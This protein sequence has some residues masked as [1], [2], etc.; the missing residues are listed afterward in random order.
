MKFSVTIFIPHL[1]IERLNARGQNDCPYLHFYFLC[2][3]IQ[4]DGV[5]LTDS[6]ANTAFLL[7]QVQTAFID[8]RDQGDGLGEIDMDGFIFRYFLIEFIRVF[9][10]AVF[11][12]GCTARAFVLQ[13]IPGLLRQGYLE[14]SCFALY[15]VNLSVRQNL[16]VG[17]PA[18]LD[19]FRGEYSH[20][21]VVG[22]EGLVELGHMA[23]DGGGFL[24]EKDLEVGTR[25]IECGL[26]PADAAPDDQHVAEGVVD[27]TLHWLLQVVS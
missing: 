12:T 6:F 20:R 17:M 7:L 21:A 22:R 11:D 4:I 27:E 16:Y 26:D 13:D 24:D 23:P 25:E 19:Q 2:R 3:L 15:P 10:R 8:I 14:V 9:D 18:D 1:R 5:I